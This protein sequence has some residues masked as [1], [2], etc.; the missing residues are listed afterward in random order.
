MKKKILVS[1]VIIVFVLAM[2]FGA[3]MAWFTDESDPVE[4]VFEAGTV[5]I[6]ADEEAVSW[7][8][9]E[10]VDRENWNPG[11]CDWKLFEITNSGSKNVFVRAKFTAKWDGVEGLLDEGGDP[12]EWLENQNVEIKSGDG[13]DEGLEGIEEWQFIA[14]DPDNP[15]ADYDEG[16]WIVV[17]NEDDEEIW[18]TA[19]WYAPQEIAGDEDATIK[20]YVDV[21]LDGPDTGNEYQ[22]ATF[23]LDATF[24][25]IQSSHEAAEDMWKV[26][27]DD[28][29][30][31]WE[32]VTDQR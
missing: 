24:E 18:F 12:I 3:T 9:D 7:S 30:N 31:D 28:D 15:D 22:E 19:Y 13:E 17:E 16:E 4:N 6:N 5:I 25:A 1:S 27:F 14:Y 32:K 23:T 20:F 10:I 8:E 11:D 21:C 2:S 26:K 29:S